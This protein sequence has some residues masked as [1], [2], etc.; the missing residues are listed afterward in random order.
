MVV[1]TEEGPLI[2]GY[3]R[4]GLIAVN[5]AARACGVDRFMRVFEAK[6]NCPELQLLHVETIGNTI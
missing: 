5:Y 4:Q 6:K 3:S 2:V 1:R